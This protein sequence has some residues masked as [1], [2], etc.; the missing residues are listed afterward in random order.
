M[1][2]NLY[3]TRNRENESETLNGRGRCHITLFQ[4]LQAVSY[5]FGMG[6]ASNFA[7]RLIFTN[8]NTRIIIYPQRDVLGSCDLFK[9]G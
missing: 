3:S 6:G 1:H 7:F 9:Y 2:T 5:S 8:A 4:F